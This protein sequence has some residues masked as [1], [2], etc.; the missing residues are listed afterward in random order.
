[1][2]SG[3]TEPGGKGVKVVV[4]S[5]GLVPVGDMYGSSDSGF[6]TGWEGWRVDG[7]IYG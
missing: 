1:M 2:S 6:R 3:D 7:V 4:V 5:G